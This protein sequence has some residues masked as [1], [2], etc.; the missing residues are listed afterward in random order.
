MQNPSQ[1]RIHAS[2]EPTSRRQRNR[3]AAAATLGLKTRLAF[4]PLTAILISPRTAA[5]EDGK[6]GN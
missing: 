6:K 1:C 4:T 3:Q 2:V 5:D